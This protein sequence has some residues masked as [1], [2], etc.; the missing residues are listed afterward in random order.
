[1]QNSFR[2]VSASRY[3]LVTS[4]NTMH[5]TARAAVHQAHVGPSL[6]S[7]SRIRLRSK[8]PDLFLPTGSSMSPA[9]SKSTFNQATAGQATH[10]RI[11]HELRASHAAPSANSIYESYR[12]ICRV[13]AGFGRKT[14]CALHC[15]QFIRADPD[16]MH[17]YLER[18]PLVFFFR[19]HI[20]PERCISL[21]EQG[22]DAAGWCRA[23]TPL[24]R[25]PESLNYAAQM[26]QA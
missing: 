6:Q 19:A 17:G 25:V 24:P 16:M 14:A 7:I 9:N 15:W 26:L 23:P 11:C 1:M 20:F 12:V 22:T 10:V 3:F 2:C 4:C 21:P 8:P 18:E 13:A 5:C